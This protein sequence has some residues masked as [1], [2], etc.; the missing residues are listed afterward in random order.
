MATAIFTGAATTAVCLRLVFVQVR[1]IAKY[2]ACIKRL[3]FLQIDIKVLDEV[4][5]NADHLIVCT[6]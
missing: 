5:H 3:N 2:M 4:L 6:L 1:K